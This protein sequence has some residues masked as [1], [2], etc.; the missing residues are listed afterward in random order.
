MVITKLKKL[1]LR[2][3]LFLIAIPLMAIAD[4]EQ[5]TISSIHA[6]ISHCYHWLDQKNDGYLSDKYNFARNNNGSITFYTSPSTSNGAIAGPGLYC[7]K[8]PVGSY[9]YGDRVIRLDFVDDIVL[10]DVKSGR[11]YCGLKGDYYSSQA[12][13]NS[14]PWDIKFYQGGGSGNTAWYVIRD[15][16]AIRQWSANSKQVESDLNLNKQFA[17]SAF[18]AHADKT[19][20]AMISERSSIG[21]LTIINN[22]AR[23]NL[24]DI[25]NDPEEMKEIPPLNLIA[26]IQNYPGAKLGSLNKQEALETQANRALE[27]IHLEISDIKSAIG[28]ESNLQ[29]IFLSA[30]NK[31][32][33]DQSLNLSKVNIISIYLLLKE[34]K[35]SIL[36]EP[37][38][39]KIW[40][41]LLKSDNVFENLVSAQ[42]SDAKDK[43]A[44]FKALPSVSEIGALKIESQ[45]AILGLFNQFA[46][47]AKR[48]QQAR[49]YIAEIFSNYLNEHIAYFQQAFERIDNKTLDASAILNKLVAQYALNDFKGFDPV[50]M[51]LLIEKN[52]NSIGDEKLKS[53]T[54][55]LSKLDLPLT[56]EETY[57]I[58]ADFT[59]DK[60]SLPSFI[61]DAQFLL[62]LFDRS[63]KEQPASSSPTNIYRFILSGFYEYF[64]TKIKKAKDD[65]AKILEQNK[66]EIF[67]L[68]LASSL[69]GS[70]KMAY[71]YPLAQNAAHFSLTPKY[72]GSFRY[73][74]HPMERF[75]EKYNKGDAQFDA[76]LEDITANSFD[77]SYLHY[78]AYL[79]LERKN[80]DAQTLL[81]IQIDAITS[82]AYDAFRGTKGFTISDA[83]K[84]DWR[85]YIHNSHIANAGRNRVKSDFCGLTQKLN[86]FNRRLFHFASDDQVDKMKDLIEEARD[87]KCF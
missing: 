68:E 78:L 69:K 53:Y 61:K 56:K 36:T 76:L 81:R 55:Q 34:S 49:P 71:T 41:A 12:E 73:R 62:M 26:R 63:L 50:Y 37:K 64:D 18:Q 67:F 48:A 66:A 24:I 42:I 28:S 70:L 54:E 8:S 9:G 86:D 45:F 25:L 52:L 13:C 7:A 47:T 44:F 58:L 35:S 17:N 83:E 59:E 15:P 80:Q 43:E 5:N 32:L 6:P 75:L 72:P 74:T 16:Q 46:D 31:M 2:N 87:Q 77:G 27:D 85:N 3:L 11:K 79:G 22:K 23:M 19:I 1:K 14:K 65:P 29:R 21:E 20:A 10:Y 4:L 33:N 84:K 38:L 82:D 51:G 60:I 57:K 40:K 39:V 30:A